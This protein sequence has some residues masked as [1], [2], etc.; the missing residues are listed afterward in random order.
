MDVAVLRRGERWELLLPP[1]PPSPPPHSELSPGAG[2]GGGPWGSKLL[3]GCEQGLSPPPKMGSRRRSLFGGAGGP[4]QPL[5][6]GGGVCFPSLLYVAL[7]GCG[8]GQP[9]PLLPLMSTCAGM[10][11]G[12]DIGGRGRDN[13]Q[14][15]ACAWCRSRV[16]VGGEGGGASFWGVFFNYNDFLWFL[17]AGGGGWNKDQHIPSIQPRAEVLGPTSPPT[18]PPISSPLFPPP[19]LSW[20]VVFLFVCF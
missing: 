1:P 4:R 6:G 18:H 16:G 13:R 12:G 3:F 19:N 20:G 14:C 5:W 10:A 8:A 17:E 2:G 7:L 15:H 11:R 9:P